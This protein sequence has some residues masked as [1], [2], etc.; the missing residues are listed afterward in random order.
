MTTDQ[1]RQIFEQLLKDTGSK[2]NGKERSE[3]AENLKRSLTKDDPLLESNTY[4]GEAEKNLK[5]LRNN[6]MT[7]GKEN[8]DTGLRVGLTKHLPVP[9]EQMDG[10]KI[11][12][13]SAICMPSCGNGVSKKKKRNPNNLV[14]FDNDTDENIQQNNTRAKQFELG[15]DVSFQNLFTTVHSNQQQSR[16]SSHRKS[17]TFKTNQQD[18]LALLSNNNKGMLNFQSSSSKKSKYDDNA[19]LRCEKDSMKQHDTLHN[20]DNSILSCN[21]PVRIDVKNVDSLSK[22]FRNIWQKHS[23]TL[24]KEKMKS[25]IQNSYSEILMRQ[26]E[27]MHERRSLQSSVGQSVNGQVK[28]TI[29]DRDLDPALY[30]NENEIGK[31]KSATLIVNNTKSDSDLYKIVWENLAGKIFDKG[32]QKYKSETGMLKS[33]WQ[34][35]SECDIIKKDSNSIVSLENS[36]ESIERIL[37][38]QETDYS[39]E[40]AQK[41]SNRDEFWKDFWH[42]NGV[43]ISYDSTHENDLFESYIDD[44]TKEVTKKPPPR[45]KKKKVKTG[46]TAEGQPET[47][48]PQTKL[49][50]IKKPRTPV[51]NLDEDNPSTPVPTP[52]KSTE[53]TSNIHNDEESLVPEAETVPKTT[54]RRRK[55][56]KKRSTPRALPTSETSQQEERAGDVT[57]PMIDVPVNPDAVDAPPNEPVAAVQDDGTILGVTVHHCDQIR[58]DPKYIAHPLV[59]VSIVDSLTGQYLNKFDRSRHV[60]SFYESELLNSIVPL[61]TQPYD[62]KVNRSLLPRWEELLIFNESFMKLTRVSTDPGVVKPVLFF[63]IRDFVTMAKANNKRGVNDKGWHNIAWA[64]LKLVN[65]NGQPNTGRKMRLQLFFPPKTRRNQQDTN[66][67]PAH[68]WWLNHPRQRYPSTLHVTVKP[69]VPPSSVAASSRS[70]FATQ[71]EEG[72]STFNEMHNS[73]EQAESESRSLAQED[74]LAAM[75]LWSRLPGQTCKIPNAPLLR[76]WGGSEGAFTLQFSHRG[77]RLAVACRHETTYPILLYGIPNGEDIGVITGHQQLVYDLQWSK[78]DRYLLSASA[79]GTAQVWDMDRREKPVHTLPHPCYVYSAS[80]HPTAQYLIATGGYDTTLRVWNIASVASQLTQ[81]LDGH[82]AIVNSIIFDQTGLNMYSAD[83]SGVII[84]WNSPAQEKAK[85]SVKTNWSIKSKIEDRDL[86]GICINSL[87]LHPHNN[88]ILIHCRDSTVRILDARIHSIKKFVGLLNH[89]Q[90]LRSSVTPCGSFIFSGSEDGCVYVWNVETGDQVAIYN[91]LG[92]TNAVHSVIYHP[93]DHMVAFCSYAPNQSILLYKF[94]SAVATMEAGF[95]V[96][97]FVDSKTKLGRSEEPAPSI[98]AQIEASKAAVKIERIKHQLDSV[99]TDTMPVGSHLLPPIPRGQDAQVITPRKSPRSTSPFGRPT[100]SPGP[101]M[102]TWGSTFDSTAAGSLLAPSYMSPHASP[103]VRA[104]AQ[105]Y[106]RTGRQDQSGMW[107]PGVSPV[108]GSPYRMQ[109][110]GIPPDVSFSM[111][112]DGKQ[113][114]NITSTSGAKPQSVVVVL[115][116]YQ[117]NRSD[118]L[119]VVRGDV[120]RVLYK[121]SANWWFGE[122]DDGKQGYFPSNYVEE[123]VSTAEIKQSDADTSVFGV[124]EIPKEK[125]VYA[126]KMP[127]GRLNF[128]SQSESEGDDERMSNASISSRQRRREAKLRDT[129]EKSRNTPSPMTVLD[130]NAKTPEQTFPKSILQKNSPRDRVADRDPSS[131]HVNI[132][133]VSFADDKKSKNS[134]AKQKLLDS[135]QSAIQKSESPE[136]PSTS[137]CLLLLLPH[138]NLKNLKQV[139]NHQRSRKLQHQSRNLIMKKQV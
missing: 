13:R 35:T 48:L 119:T 109:P 126:L 10:T 78:N 139:Q 52:R 3:M 127:G 115:F 29:H 44:T 57:P 77:T 70:M 67:E 82:K 32:S 54:E 138:G 9:K 28:F 68:D 1:T 41:H 93:H 47:D 43:E 42:G 137:K 55:K 7:K 101:L 122:K 114:L 95:R 107:K 49:K 20:Q 135:I 136:S 81:E 86:A 24:I 94:N 12:L 102:S 11:D 53:A 105:Q 22:L 110:V 74:D 113:K 37:L 123:Q 23:E 39:S 98:N 118:E 64:F 40:E 117:A 63:V 31:V 112:K 21:F 19:L 76:F 69:I 92:Y 14:A 5:N 72:L 61:M 46:G 45:T 73:L 89:R 80:Y 36:F 60:S 133:E 56:T 90:L 16:K 106:A 4:D 83:G 30:E 111:G 99:L 33:I 50:P 121:D 65:A 97:D 66:F 116:D 132:K 34:R 8:K 2:K 17:V 96:D 84:C 51:K 134:K 85:K 87:R 75:Q 25:K 130:K 15:T 125:K 91:E 129:L 71:P 104:M 88:K 26:H 58:V 59:K 6:G 120:I 27:T 124:P 62:F 108:G 131:E 100:T 128:Y 38:E 18:E 79:D 103:E